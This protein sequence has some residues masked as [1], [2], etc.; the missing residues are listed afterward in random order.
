MVTR[1]ISTGGGARGG[2]PVRELTEAIARGSEEAF[3][4]FYERYSPRVFRLLLVVTRGDEAHARELHQC[5]MIKAA[6]KLKAMHS[7]ESLWAWLAQVARNAWKDTLRRQRSRESAIAWLTVQPATEQISPGN[8]E[9][10]REALE[11]LSERERD[12]VETFYL[13]DLPQSHIAKSN[14]R[15]LKA[16][17]CELARIRR[18]LR[19][20]ILKGL[21]R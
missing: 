19:A 20:I 9:L 13:D 3:E 7:E 6:R 2:R 16:V 17:Q 10:L 8:R 18:K 14:G 11:S 5:V 21:N 12:L 15:S 4:E 1:E